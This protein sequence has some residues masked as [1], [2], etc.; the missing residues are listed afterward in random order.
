SVEVLACRQ[1]REASVIEVFDD[2]CYC[3]YQTARGLWS[4]EIPPQRIRRPGAGNTVNKEGDVLIDGRSVSVCR[5]EEPEPELEKFVLNEDISRGLERLPIPLVVDQIRLGET[6]GEALTRVWLP[7]FTY[8]NHSVAGKSLIGTA[9][10]I[11][12]VGAC[13]GCQG[14]RSSRAESVK[15]PYYDYNRS[16]NC[17]SLPVLCDYTQ[18]SVFHSLVTHAYNNSPLP[19]SS[20]AAAAVILNDLYLAKGSTTLLPGGAADRPL[21]PAAEHFIEAFEAIPPSELAS[22]VDNKVAQVAAAVRESLGVS[23]KLY[24]ANWELRRA[25]LRKSWAL[26]SV[27]RILRGVCQRE[28]SFKEREL[29]EIEW[30]NR[31]EVAL[32]TSDCGRTSLCSWGAYT[33]N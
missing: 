12:C 32:G 9:I 4:E 27:S 23:L 13:V 17:F 22:K 24:Q 18:L 21:S 33:K 10:P 11:R 7:T 2:T 19:D 30:R 5:R 25:A 6:K 3:R 28:P 29:R 14:D 8:V 26:S 1:W 31:V 16:M 20:L 15:Q